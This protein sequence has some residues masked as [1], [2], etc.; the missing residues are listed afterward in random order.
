MAREVQFPLI[1]QRLIQE[2]GLHRKQADL[3][4]A[5]HVTR[6]SISQ[7]TTG[8]TLPSFDVLV[9]LAEYFDVSM[10]YLVFGTAGTVR[11]AIDYGPVARHFEV[12][13]HGIQSKERASEA[14]WE[15]L[16]RRIDGTV[17]QAIEEMRGSLDVASKGI[18]DEPDVA[19][20]EAHSTRM[21]LLVPN[22]QEDIIESPGGDEGSFFVPVVAGNL[23]K[24]RPYRF[25]LPSSFR[26]WDDVIQRLRD[27]LR[28][29]VSG[30]QVSRLCEFRVTDQPVY[31]GLGIYTLDVEA[32]AQDEP[33]LK[34]AIETYI[35]PGDTL[36]FLQ[37]PSQD[38]RYTLLLNA[39]Y[40]N[41]ASIAFGQLWGSAKPM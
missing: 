8:R 3:A 13:L 1:L 12:A 29:D 38:F 9:R 17:Q 19:R 34:L 35:G 40:A 30:E 18:L 15:R 5:I 10:D 23:S 2:R 31:A 22:L 20:L 7:Y 11:E 16:F 27:V 37:P 4:A 33:W 36:A 6:S 28:R 26:E 41:N 32:F 25:L 21:D 24:G 39:Q 14:L